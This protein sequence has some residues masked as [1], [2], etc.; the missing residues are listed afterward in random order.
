MIRVENE[1]SYF[2]VEKTHLWRGLKASSIDLIISKWDIIKVAKSLWIKVGKN[3]YSKCPFHSEVNASFKIYKDHWSYYCYWCWENWDIIDLVQ[4]VTWKNV[5][6]S[7]FYIKKVCEI[8]EK[9]EFCDSYEERVFLPSVDES[10]YIDEYLEYCKMRAKE[11]LENPNLDSIDYDKKS[12]DDMWITN[13][14]SKDL[15]EEYSFIYWK[16]YNKVINEISFK[17]QKKIEEEE[18]ARIVEENKKLEEK[19]AFKKK[20]D[21][22]IIEKFVNDYL[23]ESYI[24]L[25]MLNLCNFS[26]LGNL[27]P[28]DCW[29]CLLVYLKDKKTFQLVFWNKKVQITHKIEWLKDLF[30]IMDDTDEMANLW[31]GYHG[32]IELKYNNYEIIWWSSFYI[33]KEYIIISWYSSRYWRMDKRILEKCLEYTNLKPI[34]WCDYNFRELGVDILKKIL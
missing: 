3:K 10:S 32:E 28:W 29:K 19:K 25:H 33:W 21:L 6:Q 20:L 26:L 22:I 23:K 15:E 24:P 4:I 5:I 18:I 16:S 1:H 13:D 31:A 7:A 17:E 9:L 14:V 34:Y 27:Y 12:L 30:T 2:E 11:L 8:K